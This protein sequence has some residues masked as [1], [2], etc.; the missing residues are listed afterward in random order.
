MDIPYEAFRLLSTDD[1]EISD[2]LSDHLHNLN[3]TRKGLVAGMMREAKI[4]VEEREMK[5]V[6]VVGN[7]NWRS[8]VLGL[9]AS[10]LV[11]DYGRPAFVWGR[12]EET[13]LKGSCRSNG[14]VN[15][16][17]FMTSVREDF[18][19]NVGGHEFSGGF[20]I[21]RENIHLLEDELI[22]VYGK[23]RKEEYIVPKVLIDCTM[24]LDEVN[25]ITYGKIEKLAPYGVGNP[26]PTFLFENIEITAVKNF[27]KEKN[28]LELVFQNSR[29]EKISAIGFFTDISDFKKEIIVGSVVNLIATFE[30]SF[31]KNRPEIRLKIVDII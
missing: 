21:S 30:K 18:F 27:G 1:E 15:M 17:D 5:D 14:T 11:E 31:F 22:S 4:R 26:K 13:E 24:T 12:G 6:I 9:L 23:V 7:P 25:D 2:V 29:G 19:I 28:H 10:R 16:V 20:S 3:D 8:G